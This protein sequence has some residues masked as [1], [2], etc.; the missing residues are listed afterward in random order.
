MLER[1][2]KV[3]KEPKPQ[4]AERGAPKAQTL[5]MARGMKAA[6]VILWAMLVFLCLRGAVSIAQGG[7]QSA[8]VD[9]G[10]LRQEIAVER[11]RDAQMLSFAEDFAREY[12]TYNAGGD[13]DYRQ[14]ISAYAPESLFS[15]VRI[16]SGSAEAISATAY[17]HKAYS[18]TQEDVWVRLTVRYTTRE[19]NATGD[20]ME[21]SQLHEATLKV[22][23]AFTSDGFIVED[24]PAFVTDARKAT[25]YAQESYTGKNAEKETQVAVEAA[26]E[27]FFRAYY[28]ENMSVIRYY[29]T[30]DAELD[31]FFGLSG[32]VAFQRLAECSVYMSEESDALLAI[33]GVEVADVSGLVVMQRFHV[34][35]EPQD[36][37]IHV[38]SINIRSKNI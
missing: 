1:K 7:T 18:D 35:L 33:V 23:I 2:P 31:D 12:L 11:A 21:T 32:R 22:P 6:R 30:P 27:N 16:G 5:R 17:R 14:R 37:Q 36:G 4:K 8:A 29:L 20:T 26:L 25:D 13:Q 9:V 34:E 3:P 19:Y 10:R 28:A 38:R 24:Y 15:A